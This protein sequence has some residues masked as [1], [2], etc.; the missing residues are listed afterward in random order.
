MLANNKI[1]SNMKSQSYQ[2]DITDL[3]DKN[4]KIEEELLSGDVIFSD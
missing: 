2:N 4:K 3:Y 1:N